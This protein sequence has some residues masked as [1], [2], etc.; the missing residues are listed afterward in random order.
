MSLKA[1]VESEI[2]KAMLAKDKDRLRALRAIKS[3][4]LLEE[5][6]GGATEQLSEEDEL[7]L[8]T[9]AA[10]QRKDSAD[11][12]QQQNREDLYAVEMAEL[13]IINEFL[14]K[15]LTEEELEAE[16]K[17]IIASVGASGPKDMGKVMGAASKT[18]AG[19]ADGKAISTKV[20]ALLS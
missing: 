10:K 1:S 11:I 9:K 6:K 19:R 4:I 12:Y 14:P 3:L 20:K 8:L 16:L 13:T 2:K 17:T 15:Q 7:K 5:T 18:L